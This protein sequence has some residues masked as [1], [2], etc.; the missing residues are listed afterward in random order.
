M[1]PLGPLDQIGFIWRKKLSVGHRPIHLPAWMLPVQP[2]RR[3][4]PAWWKRLTSSRWWQLH[5]FFG[6]FT[7]KMGGFMIQFD[8]IYHIF[9]MGWFNHQLV[10]V[11]ILGGL[12]LP[13]RGEF[14]SLRIMTSK[15]PIVS[16][17]WHGGVLKL[18]K[19]L[20]IPG[21]YQELAIFCGM[22]E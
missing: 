21:R 5:F 18:K 7:P 8:Y 6:I 1:D 22:I 9:Q 11:A 10:M 20:M 13:Q 12:T 16:N 2:S 15:S 14:C 3:V 19:P 17:S 4:T